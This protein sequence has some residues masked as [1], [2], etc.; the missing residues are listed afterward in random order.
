MRKRPLGRLPP[1]LT[2]STWR[3]LLEALAGHM[4][5]RLD[6]SYFDELK[7]SGSTALTARGT[8]LF[9]GLID[10]SN[11][12]SEELERLARSEGENRRALLREV[13][14]QGYQPV[15][16]GLDLERA[17]TGQLQE[18]FR[19]CGAD[20]N[21]GRKCLSFLLAL[22]K[23]AEIP[24]SPNLQ[25]KSRVG[26]P[27]NLGPKARAPRVVREIAPPKQ[28]TDEENWWGRLLLEKFPGLDPSWPTEIKS[29]WFDDFREIMRVLSPQ[30]SSG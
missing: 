12:P 29:K 5:S 1:Y 26:A 23:D 22:A 28:K 13:I 2:Y 14:H 27:R 21:I 30:Q 9:L 16:Q 18:H 11:K 25:G 15:L 24:L 19:E 8:L 4:P 7:F 17:T 20:G 6:R 10:A 3:R